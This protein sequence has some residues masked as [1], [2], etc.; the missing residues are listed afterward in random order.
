MLFLCNRR[1][2]FLENGCN[3]CN[4]VLFYCGAYMYSTLQR[5]AH[6]YKYNVFTRIICNCLPPYH[7]FS[8]PLH[9]CS[10]T[11]DDGVVA[12]LPF[13][14]FL[15]AFSSHCVIAM[16][17]HPST[18]TPPRQQSPHNG[19]HLHLHTDPSAWISCF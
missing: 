4:N 6:A 19:T 5:R 7:C 15:P 16:F 11:T 10:S 9:W 18:C 8:H 3:C 12:S 13:A 14:L 17:S 1:K 2:I